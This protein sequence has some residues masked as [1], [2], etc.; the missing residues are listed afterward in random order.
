MLVE[1]SLNLQL[2]YGV[3]LKLMRTYNKRIIKLLF[4]AIKFKKLPDNSH[5]LV[6]MHKTLVNEYKQKMSEI[7][8]FA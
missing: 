8:Q 7:L 4:I 5:E 1:Y 2:K 3:D 6:L